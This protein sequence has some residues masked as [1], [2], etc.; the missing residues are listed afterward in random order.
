MSITNPRHLI[1][2]AI[3]LTG[4]V[5]YAATGETHGAG[6]PR[7]PQADG[8]FQAPGW[9]TGPQQLNDDTSQTALVTRTLQQPDGAT[10]TLTLVTS[11]EP[12]LYGAGAEVPFLGNGYVV[13]ALPKDLVPTNDNVSALV[14]RRGTEQWLV[15]Y[16]FGERRGLLGNGVVPWTLAITDGLMGQANDYYKLYLVARADDLDV[17]TG[18]AFAELANAVF[19]NVAAWYAH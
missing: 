14:T 1:L 3:L 15:L 16:S 9:T 11:P 6:P 8:V 17:G 13:E 4:A 7:W 19:P 5:L 12:K 2:S 18:R 10:A